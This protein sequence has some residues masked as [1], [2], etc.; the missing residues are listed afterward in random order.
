M[1][2][3]ELRSDG[4]ADRK[5]MSLAERAGSILDAAGDGLELAVVLQRL[6]NLLKG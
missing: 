4:S 1:C 3:E 6:F 2:S 5:H